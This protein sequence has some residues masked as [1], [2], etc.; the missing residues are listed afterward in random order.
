MRQLAYTIAIAF[1]LAG[2]AASAQTWSQRTNLPGGAR[3]AAISFAIGSTV[4]TGAG[5]SSKDFYGYNVESGT[6]TRLA[7]IPGVTNERAFGAGFSIGTKGYV[8]LGY[9]GSTNLKKDLWEYDPVANTWTRKADFPGTARDGVTCFVV[10]GKAY[11]GG[12][13]DN[14][15]LFA[16]FYEY[17]PATDTWG[18][19]HD[20]QSGPAIFQA[21]FVIGQYA[22]VTTG[23]IGNLETTDLYRYDASKD[24]WD[25]LSEFP[26]AARQCAVAFALNGKGYVGLGQTGYTSSFSDF[27]S[28]DPATDTWSPAS[29]LPATKS[30]AW[31]TACVADG[32][33]YIGSGWDLG[34]NFYNDW[35]ELNGSPA[36][37]REASRLNGDW[38]AAPNPAGA[39]LAIHA[40]RTHGTARATL[41]DELGREMIATEITAGEQGHVLDLSPVPAGMY[42]LRID[43]DAGSTFQ[44]IIKQ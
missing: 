22:Y 21:S 13:S 14:K 23:S 3:D 11:V 41:I 44:K 15:V 24:S 10:N 17:D 25:Y 36:G 7:N 31:A 9:D 32:R 42:L 38:S 43:A 40:P 1:L 19:K 12:G 2:T 26:G 6:W 30:R 18:A 5:T 28:Y 27:Y 34:S 4:Y 35:W 16:D 39:T 29:G 20:L 33:A 37:I 8:C